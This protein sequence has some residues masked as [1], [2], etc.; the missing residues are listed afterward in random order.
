MRNR[1]SPPTLL[2]VLTAAV[3]LPAAVNVATGAL[4]DGWRPW[5]WLA[6]P[7]A[8][9]LA[10]PVV[11][12]ELRRPKR[13]ALDEGDAE[14]EGSAGETTW[15][16]PQHLPTFRERE[17]ILD[18]IAQLMA[19]KDGAVV[20]TGMAG[21]GKTQIAAR[22]AARHRQEF[23]IGWWVP[24]DTRVAVIASLAQLADR[25]HI[26]D[27]DQEE[28]ARKALRSLEGRGRW[29]LVFDNVTEERD[30]TGLVP[31]GDGQVLMTSR[32]PNQQRLGTVVEVPTF[33]DAAAVRFLLERT[34]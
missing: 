2:V 16:M 31:A 19:K 1:I 25:L 27:E 14:A 8:A 22:Y 30:L 28:A 12:A 17:S 20:L 11:V 18:E 24:A 29:L 4:P 34:G 10:V 32:D 7:V 6:W 13:A 33:D 5:R 15:N 21:V 9:L 23:E 3:L 26:G